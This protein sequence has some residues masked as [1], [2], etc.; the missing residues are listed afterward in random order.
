MKRYKEGDKLIYT[1]VIKRYELGG[2]LCDT[3]TVEFWAYAEEDPNG[4][5]V[6]L[7]EGGGAYYV[8]L[9]QLQRSTCSCATNVDYTTTTLLCPVHATIDPCET[10][11]QVTG[12]RRRGSIRGGRCSNCQW[13]ANKTKLH[14]CT[15]NELRQL[16]NLLLGLDKVVQNH[17][18]DKWTLEVH[19][20]LKGD[21]ME[22]I[23]T[24]GLL[25]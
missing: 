8:G 23:R 5:Y 6:Y 12:K 16:D 9:D 14:E 1:N 2:Q 17:L 22:M 19:M 25:P 13:E 4:A 20:E 3:K 11:A 24:V 10:M 7:L 21:I 15:T 18:G